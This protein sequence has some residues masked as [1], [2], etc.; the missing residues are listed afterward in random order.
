MIIGKEV[1][2]IPACTSKASTQVL[3]SSWGCVGQKGFDHSTKSLPDLK[4]DFGP[5]SILIWEQISLQSHTHLE[6][7][8]ENN[9][10]WKKQFFAPMQP[11]Q[12]DQG[13]Q[14]PGCN[15]L[16]RSLQGFICLQITTS[17]KDKSLFKPW[18]FPGNELQC[19]QFDWTPLFLQMKFKGT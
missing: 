9:T 4:S 15:N 19:Y 18:Q 3:H 10:G 1:I 11:L 14:W 7:K 5:F 12:P 6:G 8:S 17:G 13:M 2:E 16:T